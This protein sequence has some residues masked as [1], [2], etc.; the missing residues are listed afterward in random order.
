MAEIEASYNA[1]NKPKLY[2][3]VNKKCS[4]DLKKLILHKLQGEIDS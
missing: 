1:T 4:E 3:E 2:F